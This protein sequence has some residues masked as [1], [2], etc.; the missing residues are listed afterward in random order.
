MKL[1]TKF[2]LNR[3]GQRRWIYSITIYMY[4]YKNRVFPDF[5][6]TRERIWKIFS[7]KP[8][9]DQDGD[10][11]IRYNPIGPAVPE[12]IGHKHKTSIQ[13]SCCYIIRIY[14][15]IYILAASPLASSG[16]A[17]IGFGPHENLLA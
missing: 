1:P 16:F 15:Y 10:N 9:R 6:R 4:Y 13:T 12:E 8:S 2:Q 5:R 14:I 17:A 7:L 11:D 3:L